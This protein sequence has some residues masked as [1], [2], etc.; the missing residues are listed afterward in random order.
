MGT[1][2][3]QLKNRGHHARLRGNRL[4]FHCRALLVGDFLCCA[5]ARASDAKIVGIRDGQCNT[6]ESL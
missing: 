2:T 6:E 1:I 3:L 4:L 5:C